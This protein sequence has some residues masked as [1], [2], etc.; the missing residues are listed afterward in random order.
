MGDI[1]STPTRNGQGSR[2]VGSWGGHS[3]EEALGQCGS[4]AA[5][6]E[7]VLWVHTGCALSCSALSLG[8]VPD[9]WQQRALAR[10]RLRSLASRSQ[11]GTS[12][13]L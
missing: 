7:N 4:L 11:V 5:C 8:F 12:S 9:F 13:F 10:L 6:M 3:Q 2:H 1:L